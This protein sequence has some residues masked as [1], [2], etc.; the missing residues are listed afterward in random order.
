MSFRSNS[1]CNFCFCFKYFKIGYDPGASSTTFNHLKFMELL[2]MDLEDVEQVLGVL[3]LLLSAHHLEKLV[4][5]VSIID[6]VV[7]HRFSFSL[8]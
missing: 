3:E 1:R 6:I 7:I 5:Y 2:S 4:I 8:S